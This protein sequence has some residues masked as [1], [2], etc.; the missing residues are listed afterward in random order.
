MP[1]LGMYQ[2]AASAYYRATSSIMFF[3][4]MFI[5]VRNWKQPRCPSTSGWIKKIRYI[6][7][8]GYYSA[9]KNMTT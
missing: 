5:I 6:Y 8:T 3:V 2:R 9:T 1:L 7:T 4:A